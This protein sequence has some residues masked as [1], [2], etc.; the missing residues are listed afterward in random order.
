MQNIKKKLS[1]YA[2]KLDGEN[3]RN[4]RAEEENRYIRENNVGN[5]AKV[6]KG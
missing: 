5:M 6:P 4:S 2:A 1:E 3:D